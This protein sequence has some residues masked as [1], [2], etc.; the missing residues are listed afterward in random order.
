M[1]LLDN[2]N[3]RYTRGGHAIPA[4]NNVRIYSTI[5]NLSVGEARVIE[6]T[7]RFSDSSFKIKNVLA[8]FK[9]KMG[10]KCEKLGGFIADYNFR[11]FYEENDGVIFR[12]KF[13]DCTGQSLRKYFPGS[14]SHES[15]M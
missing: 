6:E 1:F 13:H 14:L 12:N 8:W 2:R 3:N 4:A 9:K 10:I 15:L 5:K 7:G 11:P